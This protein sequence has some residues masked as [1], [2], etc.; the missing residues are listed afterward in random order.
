MFVSIQFSRMQS[1]MRKATHTESR[2]TKMDLAWEE[3]HMTWR[4]LV[5]VCFLIKMHNKNEIQNGPINMT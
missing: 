4:H 5:C 2:W 1:H 3:F